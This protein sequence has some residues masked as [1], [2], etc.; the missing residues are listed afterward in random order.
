MEDRV[1]A[2]EGETKVARW[3]RIA[4]EAMNDIKPDVQFTAETA[5]DFV[6]GWLPTLDLDLKMQK[7]CISHTYYQKP[8]RTP[9]LVMDNSA[10]GSQQKNNIM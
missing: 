3:A 6:S 8:M 7:D 1:R 10:M 4:L 5:E 2:S 9:L